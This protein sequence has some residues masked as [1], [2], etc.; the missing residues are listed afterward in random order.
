MPAVDTATDFLDLVVRS[1]LLPPDVV[2]PYHVADPPGK[3][4]DSPAR[5][6]AA[7]LVRDRL[8]T[9]SQAGQLLRGKHRGF[10]LTEKYKLL[11][12]L[13]VGGMGKVFLCE[14]LLLHRLVAVKVLVTSGNAAPSAGGVERFYREARAV[15]ALDSPYVVKVH[16]IDTARGQPFMVMEYVDGPD[17][18]RITTAAGS[19]PLPVAAEY[20]RQAALGLQ[21]AHEAG[22]VHRDIKPGNVLVDRSGAVK[23]LDLGLARFY[24]DVSRNKNLTARYEAD[25]VLGTADFMSPEQITNTSEVDIRSDLYS[26]GCTLYFLLTGRHVFDEGTTPQKLIWHQF[27]EAP[28]PSSVKPDVPPEMDAVTAKLMAKNPA[29]RYQT[30]AELAAA[31]APF[32]VGGPFPP[33][34]EVLPKI[35]PSDYKLGLSLGPPPSGSGPSVYDSVAPSGDLSSPITPPRAAD[36]AT[37]G[38]GRM[39]TPPLS[40]PR[41][42]ITPASLPVLTPPP[43]PP[44]PRRTPTWVP[45]V[46]GALVTVIAVFAFIGWPGQRPGSQS[47]PAP[48]PVTPLPPPAAF[49]GKV[50]K[51]GGSTFV[52]PMMT[53]WAELYEAKAGVKIA[54]ESVG[55]GKGVEGVLAGGYAVGLTDAPLTDAQIAAAR[56]AGKAVRH[57]PLVLGAVVPAHNIPGLPREAR[58]RFTGPILAEIYLGRITRW[59]DE[60]IVANNPGLIDVL[61]DVEIEVVYRSDASGTTDIWTDY[62]ST[63]SAAWK[64]GPGKGTTVRWPVG[65]GAAK[66]VG[67]AQLVNRTPGAIGYVELSNAMQDGLTFGEVRNKAGQYVVA[68]LGGVTAA[69]AKANDR[70]PDDM[71]FSLVNADGDDAYPICGTTWAVLVYPAAGVPDPEAVAFLEWAAH[72]GQAHAAGLRYAPLPGP[73]QLRLDGVFYRLR[74]KQ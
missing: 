41:G 3:P 74:A 2:A 44:A 7:Q 17:L 72:A 15:A 50:V 42:P 65:E 35:P 66:T 53:R 36:R 61:T 51:A 20:T 69:A 24:A 56:A 39:S 18:H 33:P 43:P 60:R 1:G 30:P 26:L 70:I 13:G 21:A 5:R 4:D 9:A 23:L 22:L 28:K 19:V 49:T 45:A 38:M 11:D 52:A 64:A 68:S 14:H 34:A 55:S 58:I 46:G 32:C 10:F 31:L 63:V 6:L 62:L 59:N 40:A 71:R 67:V 27:R 12:L 29:A 16:D 37:D 47:Q 25:G 54:Y 8:L 57:V 73:L 48:D